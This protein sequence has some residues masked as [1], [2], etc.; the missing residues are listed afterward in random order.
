[1]LTA[2]AFYGIA[3]GALVLVLLLELRHAR[4]RRRYR[5]LDGEAIAHRAGFHDSDAFYRIVRAENEQ[6]RATTRK[7]PAEASGAV[8][9]GLGHDPG[10]V[11]TEAA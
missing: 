2:T 3:V 11:T 10:T 8:L 5:H 6:R 4:H 7:D 9:D 1:M